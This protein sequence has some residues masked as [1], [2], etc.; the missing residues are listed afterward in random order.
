MK[1]FLKITATVVALLLGTF[2]IAGRPLRELTGLF[3]A[4]AD[5]AV[6][7]AIDQIPTEVRDRK[8]DHDV[9]QQRQQLTDH[10]VALNLSRRELDSLAEQV[11]QLEERK[12]R[13]QRLLAEAYPV[14]Q[15]ATV[16]NRAEVEFAGSKHALADF[17]RNLD[18]LLTEDER[19][20]RVLGIRKEGLQKLQASVTDGERALVD[21][22]SA[23]V[24]LE[25]EIELLRT[26]REQAELE[27]KTLD[28][29]SAVAAVPGS[30]SPV[31][32]ETER[33]RQDV[34]KMEAGNEARRAAVPAAGSKN[35]VA[36]D[37]ERLERLKAIHG[38]A[39]VTPKVE[40]A[41]EAPAVPA[42]ATPTPATG[43]EIIK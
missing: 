37:W 43:G 22:R 9:Q 6:D 8:L 17:Q 3:A 19:E 27:G 36:R 2:V 29:V 4:G 21:M 41:V 5:V 24:A 23:L 33:L 28:M 30:S 7:S 10:Q 12:G 40:A 13:R 15:Q 14:L 20:T 18:A 34:G 26:R 39:E 31:G 38:G 25:Q 11:Q 42:P 32:A 16:E 1:L 35:V